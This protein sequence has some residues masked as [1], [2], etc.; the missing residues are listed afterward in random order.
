M[1][2]SEEEHPGQVGPPQ[3]GAAQVGTGE[4]GPAQIRVAQVGPDQQ[5]APEAGPAQVGGKI[6]TAVNGAELSALKFTETNVTNGATKVT[7]V[8]ITFDANT[9]QSSVVTFGTDGAF[10]GNGGTTVAWYCNPVDSNHKAACI[11]GTDAS[12]ALGWDTTISLATISVTP[13]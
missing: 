10:A 13:A 4:V 2:I 9:P 6:T 5:G 12:T 1:R 8:E 3:V 11:V 7:G